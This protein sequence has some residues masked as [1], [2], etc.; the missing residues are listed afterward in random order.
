MPPNSLGVSRRLFKQGQPF[1]QGQSFSCLTPIVPRL[2]ISKTLQSLF[3]IYFSD[4]CAIITDS[5]LCND[6][7]IL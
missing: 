4:F 7:L 1:S 2:I 5:V 3:Y 6:S